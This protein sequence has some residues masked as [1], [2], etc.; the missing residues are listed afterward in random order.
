MELESLNLLF[1]TVCATYIIYLDTAKRKPE[2]GSL[3]AWFYE[4][5]MINSIIP[6]IFLIFSVFISIKID[7]WESIIV[8]LIMLFISKIVSD[9]LRA[10]CQ[11]LIFI[12]YPLGLYIL[13]E[14]IYY[15]DYIYY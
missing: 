5:N 15:K 7:G 9:F 13:K 8:L 14:Y 6:F 3:G 1:F 2:Y 10:K 12:I 11:L 4:V